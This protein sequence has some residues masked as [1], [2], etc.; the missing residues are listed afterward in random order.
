MDL[1]RFL[2]RGALIVLANWPTVVV[3]FAARTAFQALLAVPVVGA[4][5]LVAV[6]LGTDAS[7]LLDGGIRDMLTAVANAL[8]SEPVALTAFAVAF[9]IVLL[10]GSAFMAFVKGGTV[11]VLVAAD[12]DAGPIERELLHVDV[13][14]RASRFDMPRFLDGSGRLFRRYVVLGFGLLV[15]YGLS[16]G[17]CLAF[18][19]YGYRAAEGPVLLVGY[20]VAATVAVAVLGVWMT[21][22]N[23]VYLLLQIAVAVEDVGVIPAVQRV[24]RFIRVE[25]RCLGGIF[26]VLFSMVVIATLASALAWSGVAL[27]AFVPLVGLAVVPLQIAA[28]LVR[29]LVFEYIGLTGLGAY[30]ALYRRHAE[31]DARADARAPLGPRPVGIPG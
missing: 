29:G 3:Q 9:G 25:I 16:A 19:W 21:L 31:Q 10:G 11:T 6:L 12:G 17:G 18:L 7:R 20:A 30:L 27:V 24:A 4:A 26:V 13:L 2:K 23:L 22:V 8:T 14:R 5:V 1:K 28:L 15:V